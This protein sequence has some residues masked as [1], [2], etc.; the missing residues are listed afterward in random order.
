MLK[1]KRNTSERE[2]E[3]NAKTAKK[4]IEK[5]NNAIVIDLSF[6]IETKELNNSGAFSFILSF[7]C[8]SRRPLLLLSIVRSAIALLSI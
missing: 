1:Q 6:A 5:K 8:S 2:F 7:S 3:M 4:E